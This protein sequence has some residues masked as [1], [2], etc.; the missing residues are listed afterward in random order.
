MAS[1]AM[2]TAVHSQ[3]HDIAPLKSPDATATV[4]PGSYIVVFKNGFKSSD[5]SSKSKQAQQYPYNDNDSNNSLWDEILKGIKH[6]IDLGT[7]QAF[8]GRFTAEA[9]AEIRQHPAVAFVEHDTI[10][11]RLNSSSHAKTREYRSWGLSTT[12]VVSTAASAVS[13]AAS[14]RA[15]L[16][17]I[18]ARIYLYDAQEDGEGITISA[19]DADMTFGP[20]DLKAD[21]DVPST[22][23]LSTSTANT[24]EKDTHATVTATSQTLSSSTL[25]FKL[26][27]ET[28]QELLYTIRSN[29]VGTASDFIAVVDYI[30]RNQL[31][32][33]GGVEEKVTRVESALSVPFAF[34]NSRA[35][36]LAVTKAFDSGLYLA[37]GSSVMEKNPSSTTSTTTERS[38]EQL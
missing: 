32:R 25:V 9:L 14:Q 17:K 13:I 5:F 16:D 4:S 30:I 3:S 1:Q 34:S 22:P 15:V 18:S 2:A 29:G 19:A 28:Q 20:Q 37:L 27:E 36:V 24:A 6:F 38:F 31:M 8:A 7:F 11:Q 26:A 12:S 21:D 23:E 10:G 35:I 33:K